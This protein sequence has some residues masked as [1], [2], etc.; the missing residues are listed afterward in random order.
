M[1][2]ETSFGVDCGR[3]RG[4]GADWRGSG[5]CVGTAEYGTAEFGADHS[6][7]AS[8]SNG[9]PYYTDAFNVDSDSA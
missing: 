9:N 5:D 7:A 4:A 6:N 3:N 1:K 8:F 2:V